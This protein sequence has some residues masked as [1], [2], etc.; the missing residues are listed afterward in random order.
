M[1]PGLGYREGDWDFSVCLI[2]VIQ[3]S[4]YLCATN[5]ALNGIMSRQRALRQISASHL[6]NSLIE[7]RD[8]V[9]AIHTRQS[10]TNVGLAS[11]PQMCNVWRVYD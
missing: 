9:D 5:I 1:R 11:I 8:W 10:L 3:G 6:L 7:G 2:I 4:P